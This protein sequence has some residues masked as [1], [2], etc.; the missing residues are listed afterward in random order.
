MRVVVLGSAAGG[1]FPQWNCGCES[2]A[3]ARAGDP[4]VAARTQDSIAVT[5][6]GERWIVVNASPDILQQ[7]KERPALHPR[8][9]RNSPIAEIVLTNGD[10]DHV[11]GLF[12]LRESQPL[13]VRATAPVR[14]GIE[15]SVFVETLRRFEGQ[16]TW[17]DL[18]LDARADL[19]AGLALTAFAARGKLPVHLERSTAPSPE[20]NVGLAFEHA[21]KRVV[22]LAAAASLDGVLDRVRGA[23]VLFFDGTFWSE[24]ELVAR[25]LGKGRA[26]DM[27]H[28]P[29]VESMRALAD[30]PIGRKIFTHVNNTNPILVAG[31]PER[32]AIEAA[33][34]ELAFDG[35]EITP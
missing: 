27:A 26:R 23:D 32:A 10:M 31:S 29:V 28:M 33:G 16:L 20:D 12:S 3:L 2:C 21:G 8:A 25:G 19:G 13:V 35:M 18:S 34:W 22:Y 9:P 4:R 1:G 5:A 30:V 14:R 15:A 6:D 11:L 7:I 17:G 24:D